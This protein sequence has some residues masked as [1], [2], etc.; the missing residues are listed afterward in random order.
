MFSLF[1]I[2]RDWLWERAGVPQSGLH[3]HWAENNLS[4]V[5]NIFRKRTSIFALLSELKVCCFFVLHQM[6]IGEGS[7]SFQK[8][9]QHVESEEIH[10]E[11]QGLMFSYNLQ[12]YTHVR[13]GEQRK[14]SLKRSMPFNIFQQRCLIRFLNITLRDRVTNKRGRSKSHFLRNGANYA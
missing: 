12:S 1:F 14:G 3:K 5:S 9:A 8:D 7:W 10:I 6:H 11:I 2:L 4:D 13:H